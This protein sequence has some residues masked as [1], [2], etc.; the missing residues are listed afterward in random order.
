MIR[1][2]FIG[3]LLFLSCCIS[4]LQAGQT[5]G[6]PK[7][8]T[9]KAISISEME[10][11]RTA[12]SPKI[13]GRLDDPAWQGVALPASDWVSYNPLYGNRMAQHT[14]VWAGYDDTG[15]YF[16]FHCSDPEPEKIKTAI[17][18]RDTIFNDDWVGLSLDALGSHQSSYEFFVNPSG[19][20]ADMLNS[21]T[22]G[23]DTSPD[24]V[25]ESAAQRTDDG[26]DVEIHIPYKTIRFK[27]GKDVRMEVL[28]WRRVSRLGMS[29]SWPDLPPGTSIFTRHAPLLLHDV[30]RPLT[31]ELIPN[32]T[33][34]MTQSRTEPN[35]WSTNSDPD[36]GIT[37]KYGISSTVTLDGT[38]RP[39]FSQV[40]SDAFQVEVNQRYPIFYGEKR[41]FF[42]EGMGTFALAGSGGDGNMQTAVHTRRI[43]DPVFGVKLT[44]TVGKV[45]FAGLSS[46]DRSP[47]NTEPADPRFDQR[48]YF[49][50][51]RALYS[52]GKGTYIG[53]L[54][55]DTELGS[56]Y[57]RV[58]AGDISLQFGEH[59]QVTATA[60]TS[61][62][63]DLDGG[64]A[65]DGM[66]G[67]AT[68]SYSSK[69]QVFIS[70]FEH[71][72]KD[73]QMDTAFYNR[74]GITSNWTYYCRNFYPDEQRY[75]WF[76]KFAPFVW[77]HHDRDRIQ[78]GN[79]RFVLGGMRFNF[80]RQGSFRI[81]Y[82]RGKE[83]WAGKQFDIRQIQLMG[84]AQIL[85]WL[86]FFSYV[87][88]SRSIYY[89]P[90]EPFSG[91]S[92]NIHIDC[93]IQPTPK[94][95][96]TLSYDHVLFNR[97][98]D[99]RRIYTVDIINAKTTYQFNKHLSVRAIERYDSSRKNVLMD[100]LMSYEPVPGT[101]AYAGYGTLMDK[102]N[103]DGSQFVRENGS[104][105]NTQR[106]LFF[107]LSYLYR[108]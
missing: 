23:E 36:G 58:A 70:Q 108:F 101:V 41:P 5:Q 44:G 65:R 17:S 89:D 52:L 67:Q 54:V 100:Y 24:W 16:A 75:G 59:Q 95:S 92:R 21:S 81:D 7:P 4:T 6:T 10:L 20:Q 57:N 50:I 30:K 51:G 98:S 106:S 93:K 74:T 1:A 82:G 8:G 64:N 60:I 37:G 78:G 91:T 15:L 69:Q 19:I 84:G 85:R 49:N 62:S 99:G 56:G 107:K 55:T 47:G 31:L 61:A 38:Y 68:Y 14:K 73:F 76:K 104:F 53:G 29:A 80:T 13:D 90:A 63:K 96:Q 35:R 46:S 83:A 102:Q 48:E 28:F 3:I 88:F 94:L 18:R 86:N 27:S 87:N 72:D 11:L 39:D 2:V 25:W 97:M 32:L 43:I 9:S 71:Y 12:Q 45:T 33:Y 34:A 40:E 105:L 42:M 79:E 77:I 22:A 26:Y 103:W 66:A